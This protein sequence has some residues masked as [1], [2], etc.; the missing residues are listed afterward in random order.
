MKASRS[1]RR[2]QISSESIE[3]TISDSSSPKAIFV[4]IVGKYGWERFSPETI[5]RTNRLLPSTRS[6][7]EGPRGSR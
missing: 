1:V 4:G 6:N 2:K 3:F 7:T 5:E